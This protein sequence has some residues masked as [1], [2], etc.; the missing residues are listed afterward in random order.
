MT[1]FN[2]LLNRILL[3]ISLI[4]TVSAGCS[5]QQKHLVAPKASQHI[6]YLASEDL[7]GRFPGTPGDS[8]AAAYIQHYFKQLNTQ[9]L[10][11]DGLQQFPV[12][13]GIKTGDNNHLKINNQ[14]FQISTD[15]QPLGFSGNNKI[16]A[17]VVFVGYGFNI[18]DDSIQWNDYHQ[19]NVKG[20]WVLALRMD[21]DLDNISSPF[22]M[23]GQ[24]RYKAMTA[25]DNGA[26]G[27][28]LV[29]P[30]DYEK[31][32]ILEPYRTSQSLA[33]SNI[34]VIQVTRKTAN[35]ILSPSGYTVDS[36]EKI[37]TKNRFPRSFP[38]E[39][40]VEGETDLNPRSIIT[41]NI[42]AL[43]KGTTFPNEYIVVGAH[44]D[45]LGLGGPDGG[46]RWRDTTAVHP[47]ADDNASG[48]A[49]VIELAKKVQKN[50]LHRSVIF[51]A[52]GAEEMGLL[53]SRYF[54][55]NPPVPA[56]SIKAM[57]NFDMVGR[58]DTLRN[59][60]I[61]GTATA[62]ELELVID[63]IAKPFNFRIRKNPEGTGPSDHASFYL[64]KIPVLFFTTGVHDD[65]HTPN[66][67]A[68]LINEEGLE[69]IILLSHNLLN[70]LGN[71]NQS[72]TFNEVAS[73]Q[74]TVNRR[75][76][77]ATLGVIPDF[78]SQQKGV[79]I[80]GVRPG[81]P[82]HKAGLQKGDVIVAIDGNPIENIYEY[83]FRLAKYSPGDRINVDIRR[84]NEIIVFLID[85]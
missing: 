41:Q 14:P 74:P 35:L 77:K 85:L 84:N 71:S 47:G 33:S 2:S 42:A 31:E 50:P 22:A 9:L 82:A 34:P 60:S 70:K 20:K 53:G 10:F 1:S 36:L 3:A 4:A 52:F 75:R 16:K 79:G 63:S 21:P 13:T 19:V 64:R 69:S 66:D 29:N 72:I 56:S 25:A 59:L 43:V 18:N 81:G 61:G 12:I 65:Y 62:L 23:Y 8:M 24:D 83:M 51:V 48:V 27:L 7:A 15:F 58:L 73:A 39:S 11:N 28:I 37:I 45:H 46:S 44:Y 54:V 49:A 68:H 17:P 80:D 5:I 38:I 67:K 30:T 32:D 40:E 6:Q 26:A 76:L 57:L 55:D 78:A